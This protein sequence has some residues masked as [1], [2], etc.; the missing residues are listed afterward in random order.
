MISEPCSI[1]LQQPNYPQFVYCIKGVYI[2]SIDDYVSF[3]VRRAPSLQYID[4]SSISKNPI[5]LV[6]SGIF[7]E[8]NKENSIRIEQDADHYYVNKT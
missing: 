6:W 4:L 7:Y 3:E 2:Q 5:G 1:T 8:L